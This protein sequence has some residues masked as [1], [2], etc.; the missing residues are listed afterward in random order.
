MELARIIAPNN[1]SGTQ[2]ENKDAAA[3]ALCT[4]NDFLALMVNISGIFQQ[5]MAKAGILS[6]NRR[7]KAG[8]RLKRFSPARINAMRDRLN[9][10]LRNNLNRRK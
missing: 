9:S 8:A 7:S 10:S 5:E 4:N 3:E 2:K 6:G 1:A